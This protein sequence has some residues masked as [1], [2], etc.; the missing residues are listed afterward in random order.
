MP[1]MKAILGATAVAAVLATSGA[2]A[3]TSTEVDYI[4]AVSTL[5]CTDF[6]RAE[7]TKLFTAL[8]NP[9]VAYISENDSGFGS[10]AN[11]VDYMLTE[12]RLHESL[13]V[14]K[15][16]D[17]LFEKKRHHRLPLIP[18]GGATEDPKVHAQWDAFDK[19]L[20]HSGPR[21]HFE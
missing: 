10:T 21:P 2:E 18:M 19:W 11:I 16:V 6:L 1:I 13:T 7:G 15:A 9:L 14:G 17:N 12:C 4:T 5:P 8:T 3:M 20:H